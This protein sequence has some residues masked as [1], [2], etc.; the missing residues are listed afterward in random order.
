[1][2][3]FLLKSIRTQTENADLKERAIFYYKLLETDIDAAE[4]IITN[5]NEVEEFLED[6]DSAMKSQILK[7]FNTM[8]VVFNEPESKFLKKDLVRKQYEEQ[9]QQENETKKVET[10]EETTDSQLSPS[11]S[12]S[13]ETSTIQ[14]DRSSQQM[15]PN[16]IVKHKNEYCIFTILFKDLDVGG[17]EERGEEQKKNEGTGI[18]LGGFGLLWN[19]DNTNTPP[20]P[21]T[22][23]LI[24]NPELASLEFQNQWVSFTAVYSLS[25]NHLF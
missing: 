1:M 19:S 2:L 16:L 23:Q 11:P 6:E 9:Q 24:Q 21:Q 17:E 10:E 15:E 14:S 20:P 8:S 22:L 12:H 7:E 3:G 13:Q 18:D 4:K 5:E 25:L